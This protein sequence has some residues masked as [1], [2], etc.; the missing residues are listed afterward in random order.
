MSKQKSTSSHATPLLEFLAGDFA[1]DMARLWALPHEGFLT[2][3][4]ARRHVA[5]ILAAGLARSDVKLDETT[6]RRLERD[7]DADLSTMVMGSRVPGFMKL[8]SKAGEV[9]WKEQS[10]REL[11]ELFEEPNANRALRHLVQV[12]PDTFGP[13]LALPA[14]LREANILSNIRNEENARDVARAYALALRM[15]GERAGVSIV[16]RWNSAR[17][18]DRFHAM[19]IDDLCPDVFRPTQAAP[20]LPQPFQRMQTRKS[21]HALAMEFHNCLRDYTED[22]ARGRMAVYAWHVGSKRAAIA[23]IWD[24]A[25]WRLAEAEAP[26]NEALEE[27]TLR[28]IIPPLLTAGVRTGP[29]LHTI[30]GRLDTHRYGNQVQPLGPG[31]VELLALGDL[32]N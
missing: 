3:P 30:V 11:L 9:L 29:S 6:Q 20:E 22:V 25:G 26:E 32:W 23:L 17:N 10:Y 1:S 16:S 8:L 24:A 13:M 31:F 19:V 14:P 15:R 4:A 27:A 12:S 2:L 7:R 5:A 18:A 21:L 28:D